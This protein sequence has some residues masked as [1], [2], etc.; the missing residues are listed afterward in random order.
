MPTLPDSILEDEDLATFMINF[1]PFP[2]SLKNSHSEYITANTALLKL[3]GFSDLKALKGKTDQDL[4]CAA[5][6]F[7]EEFRQQ[8]K[9][10]IEFGKQVN[11][12]ICR[13]ADEKIHCFSSTKTPIFC[14]KNNQSATLSCMLEMDCTLIEKFASILNSSTK[15]RNMANIL[16]SYSTRQREDDITLSKRQAQSLFFLLRGKTSK[17]I[18]RIL[19]LSP[20]TVDEYIDIMKVKFHCENRLQLISCAIEKGYF[21][22]LPDM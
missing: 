18:A 20:R 19:S 4:K 6:N 9:R 11:I 3:C 7:S 21:F 15:T 10:S 22:T 14:K 13:Y 8:D 17:E 16:G 12:D 5:A 1:L 2:A